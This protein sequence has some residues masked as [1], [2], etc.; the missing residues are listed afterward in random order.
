MVCQYYKSN[1]KIPKCVQ[2]YWIEKIKFYYAK[3][4]MMV[5]LWAMGLVF[6]SI[7][8]PVLVHAFLFFQIVYFNLI[9]TLQMHPL[10]EF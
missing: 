4:W 2:I 5:I 8:V 1:L 6:G 3:N 10:F 9:L 7:F